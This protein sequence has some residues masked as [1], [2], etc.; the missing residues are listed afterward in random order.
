MLRKDYEKFF[1]VFPKEV[2]KLGLSRHISITN[3]KSNSKRYLPFI[4]IEYWNSRVNYSFIDIFPTDYVTDVVPN[5]KSFHRKECLSYI[6]RL[7]AGEKRQVALN[8]SFQKLHVSKDETDILMTGVEDPIFG[9]VTDKNKVFPLK[10][11]KF[12]NREYYCPNDYMDYV[13][14]LYGGDYIRIPKTAHSHNFMEYIASHDN[15][16]E[17]FEKSIETMRNVNDNFE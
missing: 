1:V 11:M 13:K 14:K 10:T 2:S 7:R 16:Y 12:E 17:N 6:D 9:F 8:E 4:K 5:L 3:S 15:I